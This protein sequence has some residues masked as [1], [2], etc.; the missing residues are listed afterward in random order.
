MDLVGELR[1]RAR[2]YGL[3]RL[4]GTGE[5]AQSAREHADLVDL[6]EHGTTGQAETLIRQ[7]IHHVRGGWA[8][9]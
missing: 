8:T 3:G 2:L 6:L 4:A 5:L 7:H 1:S 9:P